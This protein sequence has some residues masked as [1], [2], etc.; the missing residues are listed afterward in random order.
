YTLL[1][2]E[3]K[4]IISKLNSYKINTILSSTK[5]R[6]TYWNT[7]LSLEG[8]QIAAKTGTSNKNYKGIIRANNLWTIGYTPQIVTVVWSGNTSGKALNAS[9][10]GLMASGP[11]MNDFM[12]FAHKDLKKETWKFPK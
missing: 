11:I 6:P 3:S 2:K 8:I 10:S 1:E 5:D 12:E 4:R 9:A 7:F